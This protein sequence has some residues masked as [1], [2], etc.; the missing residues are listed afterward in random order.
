MVSAPLMLGTSSWR[1]PSSLLTSMASPRLTWSGATSTGLPSSSA[2]ESFMAGTASSART[3][4]YPIRWV[5]ETLPP[6]PRR[7]WLLITMRLSI[8]SLAGMS[9]TLVAVGTTRLLGHVR[10]PSGRP[11]PAAGGARPGWQAGGLRLRRDR[12]GA[13][14]R[15]GG[16]RRWAAPGS[17]GPA[18]ALAARAPERPGTGA[19]RALGAGCGMRG[20]RRR[21]RAPRRWG[22]RSSSWRCRSTGSQRRSSTRPGR[23]I[24]G[25]RG[26]AGTARPPAT[27]WRRSRTHSG[28]DRT[29]AAQPSARAAAAGRRARL[30]AG[31][32][33]TRPGSRRSAPPSRSGPAPI[34]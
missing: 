6:R 19:P 29:R 25:R 26:S 12:G 32:E 27:G 13:R 33:P 34:H 4:A 20:L 1:E 18:G 9:R 24:R 5:N 31:S 23:R 11:R 10:R 7:R 30:L 2:N 22:G 21:R 14:G 15:R 16:G 8:S 3:T 28:A 17:P